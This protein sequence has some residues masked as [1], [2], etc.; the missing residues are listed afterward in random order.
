MDI[1]LHYHEN[2][3]GFPLILLHG[4]GES[5]AY[6]QNQL[7]AFGEYFR[8][9][10]LDTRGHGGSPR[11]TAPFSLE[12]FAEDLHSF[13]EEMGIRRAHILGFSDGANIALLFALRYPQMVEKLI[14]NGGH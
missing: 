5:S 4:N 2:G 13:M 12:Q 7:P 1:Q 8:V 10:A 14:L 11:G 6:F 9:I 3:Q